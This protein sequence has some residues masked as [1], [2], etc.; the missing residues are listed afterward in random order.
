V[1]YTVLYGYLVGWVVT[2]IALALAV[3]KLQDPVSPQSHPISL[4][5]AAG[6]AWPLVIIGAAQIATIA[7]VARSWNSRSIDKRVRAFTDNEIDD[8]LDELLNTPGADT[9]TQLGA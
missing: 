9:H 4:A 8:L 7:L 3:R 1:I 5:V 2:S 6:A